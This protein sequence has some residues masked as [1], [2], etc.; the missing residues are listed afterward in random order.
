M[1][2]WEMVKALTENP[3]ASFVPSQERENPV[4]LIDGVLCW[5][6]KETPFQLNVRP[7]NPIGSITP[8]GTLENYDWE[9]VRETVDFMTAI[10]SRKRVRPKGSYFDKYG[11][12][13]WIEWDLSLDII[14]GKWYIE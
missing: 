13:S 10:N 4:S 5:T 7:K 3:K 11:F 14:N 8:S 9:L 6:K 1:K 12:R 2:T